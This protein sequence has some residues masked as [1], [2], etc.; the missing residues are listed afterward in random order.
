METTQTPARDF[1]WEMFRIG[2]ALTELASSLVEML[3]EDAY[4]GEEPGEVVL[5]MMTGTI[6]PVVDAAG[7]EV[8]RQTISLM[9]AAYDRVMADMERALELTRE[10]DA[11]HGG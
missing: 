1:V 5:D 11:G 2:F 6:Q 10:R 4:P 8:A 7:P 3:P 9:G